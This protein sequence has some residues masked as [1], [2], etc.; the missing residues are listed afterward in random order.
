MDARGDL[1]TAVST[2]GLPWKL[3]G[4]VGD[5]PIL[6]A[7]SYVDNEVGA[8]CATGVGELTLRTCASFAVVERMRSGADPTA[9]CTAVLNQILRITPEVRTNPQMQLAFIAMNKR[10]QVGAAVYRKQK[11][12][13]RYALARGAEMPA[14]H[15]VTPLLPV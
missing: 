12:I 6:G 2:S 11:K 14:L 9:A 15:E 4:R 13:F 7:G 10:G 1:A 8:A 3:A 5:S